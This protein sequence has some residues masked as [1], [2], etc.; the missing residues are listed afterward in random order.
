M[1]RVGIALGIALLAVT[2]G[3]SRPD[4]TTGGNSGPA[5][6]APV[7]GDWAIVQSDTEPDRLN[8]VLSTTA[9]STRIEYGLND[10]NVFEALLQYDP[11]DWTFTKPLLAEAYP[12]VSDDHLIYTF[13][14][15]DGVK[16]HDGQPFTEDDVLFSMKATMFPLIDDARVRAVFTGLVD[17]QL[18]GPRKIQYTFDKPNFLN[19][20]NL[21][22]GPIIAKHLFDPEGLLDGFTYKDI[23]S[24]KARGDAK[25][26]Q[27]AEAFNKHPADRVPVGT[28]PYKFDQCDTGKEVALSRNGDY[29]GAKPHLDKIVYRVIQDRT[30][31]LTAL[32]AGEVD[33]VPRLLP[34]QYAQQTS[35]QQFESQFEKVLYNTTQYGYIVWNSERPFFKDKRVRR[36]LTM[37]I[38][39][40][41][42]IE[43]LRG[44]LAQL[45]ESHFNP[46][47]PDYNKNLQPIPFDPAGA[48]QLLD[49]SGWKDSNGDGIR[50]K[51]GIPFRFEFIGSANSVFTAQLMP[52]L[53]E[54]FRKAGIEMKERLLEFNVQV[55]NLRDHKFDAT[56]LLWVSPLLADPYS[57]WH[58][59]SIANRGS[60]YASF[61]NA[62]SDRL[63]EQARTEFDSDK[64]RQLYYRW[65]EIIYDEQPY[66][67]LYVPRDPAAYQKRFQ[68]VN[69][70]PPDPAYNLLEWFAPTA[71]Q[72]Y[73]NAPN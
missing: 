61:R 62:E 52:V 17:V 63:L 25:G 33:F 24:A 35:G 38:D 49:E 58:S 3:C 59:S 65:Q 39:R 1:K 27:F 7:S 57:I 6:A 42:I 44:G 41:Q 43:T 21:G 68:N 32:K 10:S 4:Q 31:S 46:N 45:T 54:Q 34:I 70:Y 16:W 69:W 60:N 19:V 71:S 2:F 23:V 8:P 15:R 29:W 53:R 22:S 26:K 5:T 55:E 11:K 51:D 36:A 12:E 72:K 40:K 73:G 14:I 50:D 67:F 13:T 18:V 66:T 9:I 28:G 64:R 48:A 37:L 56:T 47:S 30:A 20:F